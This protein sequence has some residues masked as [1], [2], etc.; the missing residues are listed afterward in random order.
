MTRKAPEFQPGLILLDVLSGAFRA[1]G[2]TLEGWCKDQGLSGMNMR[3]A[4]L[5]ASKS[6]LA[7]KWLEKAI[8]AAGREFVLK[9]YRDRVVEHAMQL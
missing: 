8:E 1:R 4:A 7:K 3:N 9:V 2:T 6:E 5:G